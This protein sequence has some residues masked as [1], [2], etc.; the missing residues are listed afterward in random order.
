MKDDKGKV[1]DE[2]ESQG[3]QAE[4]EPEEIAPVGMC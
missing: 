1:E 4:A 3:G 2:A